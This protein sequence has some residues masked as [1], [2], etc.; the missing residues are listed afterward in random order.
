V[1]RRSQAERLR[2]S[3]KLR[4]RIW[5]APRSFRESDAVLLLLGT[6]RRV[7][8]TRSA[9]SGKAQD[10]QGAPLPWL[11]YPAVYWLEAALRGTEDVLEFGSGQSTLWFADRVRSVVSVEHD[12]RWADTIRGSPP[13]NVRVLVRPCGGDEYEADRSD[14][15]VRAADDH[16]E[17]SF[18]V[19]V[20]DG[21]AR[22]TVVRHALCRLKDSGLVVVDNSDRPSLRPALSHLRD[23]EFRRLDFVGP[24]PGGTNFSCTSVFWRDDCWVLPNNYPEWWG[25]DILDFRSSSISPRTR[26]I[27][28]A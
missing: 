19:L 16:P 25:S 11:T 15:Y 24:V 10:Q 4:Y 13:P 26:W 7:G 28:R 17:G 21:V 14:A 27:N 1:T 23:A 22:N 12:T 6:M 2:L 20:V 8:W 9:A 5:A 3:T 18:D